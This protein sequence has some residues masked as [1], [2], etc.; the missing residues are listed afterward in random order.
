MSPVGLE[1]HYDLNTC[2]LPFQ[3]GDI[4]SILAFH[5]FEHLTP[6]GL[7]HCLRECE[8]VLQP[9]GTLTVCVPHYLG[10]MAYN[11]AT[12]R[13]LFSSDIW[14]HMFD[15]RYYDN[16]KHG[17][18]DIQGLQLHLNVIMGVDENNLVM[19]TQFVRA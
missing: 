9:G 15:T 3:N 13:I 6:E 11:D 5:V 2:N 8:R 12:H 18:K 17:G 14:K 1:Q 7:F 4:S 10:R 19:L 16:G